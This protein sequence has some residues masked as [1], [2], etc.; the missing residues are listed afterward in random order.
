MPAISDLVG[1]LSGN[2]DAGAVTYLRRRETAPPDANGAVAG[3]QLVRVRGMRIV[4]GLFAGLL[5]VASNAA[6]A[7]TLSDA[8]IRARLVAE[9]AR[10]YPGNCPCPENLDSA[11]RRCGARSAYSRT[12][13]RAVMC[14]PEDV[15]DEQVRNYRDTH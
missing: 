15:T 8:E 13:G 10:A 7:G 5:L 6:G 3:R 11:G 14:Y 9:S 12:G 4:P 2:A 1:A